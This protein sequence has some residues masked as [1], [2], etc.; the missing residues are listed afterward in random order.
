MKFF[1][2]LP[3][4]LY[5]LLDLYSSKCLIT[6]MV[7]R[8]CKKSVHDVL[9]SVHCDTIIITYKACIISWAINTSCS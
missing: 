2:M 5:F 1:N 4:F 7:I 3:F 8:V 9:D 6:D